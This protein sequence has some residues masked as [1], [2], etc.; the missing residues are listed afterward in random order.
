MMRSLFFWPVWIDDARGRRVHLVGAEWLAWTRAE[1]A[2]VSRHMSRRGMWGRISK[3]RLV[4]G[5]VFMLV[6]VL[7]L[8]PVPALLTSGVSRWLPTGYNWL[9]ILA[10]IPLG[11][12]P[13][14]VSLNVSR[15]AAAAP[16]AEN[17]VDAGR[18]A[19]C[20]YALDH[21]RPDAD[22]CT[23]CAEC[24]AAWRLDAESGAVA[25]RWDAIK[26]S[27]AGVPGP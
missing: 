6:A 26:A 2:A 3:R 10:S 27:A 22:G 20:A 9:T 18:C 16:M 15:W 14:V 7:V 4:V 25:R 17:F 23:V 19:S 5:I 13:P 11:M 24:G 8:A 1:R 12:V 21:A